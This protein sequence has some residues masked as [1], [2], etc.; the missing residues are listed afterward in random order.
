MLRGPTVSAGIGKEALES[1]F[2]VCHGLIRRIFLDAI[3]DC[4]KA[5]KIS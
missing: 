1:V 4:A 5:T 3:A 2:G